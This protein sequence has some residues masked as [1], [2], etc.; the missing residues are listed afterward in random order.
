MVPTNLP[1]IERKALAKPIPFQEPVIEPD[2]FALLVPFSVT[3]AAS[4]YSVR[5]LLHLHLYYDAIIL[6]TRGADLALG[7]EG[8]A[9]ATGNSPGRRADR[10]SSCTPICLSFPSLCVSSP[11]IGGAGR[12]GEE[13]PLVDEPAGGGTGAGEPGE[14]AAGAGADAG[15][16]AQRAGARVP[17]GATRRVGRAGCRCHRGP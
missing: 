13:E 7:E 17:A 16:A 6:G 9:R 4:I 14:P 11:D 3:Q 5:F 2:P 10:Y 15:D 12:G 8:R 1:P